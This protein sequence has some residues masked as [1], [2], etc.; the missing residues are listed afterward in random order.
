[1]KITL[2]PGSLAEQLKALFIK[3]TKKKDYVI[4]HSSLLESLLESPLPSSL[5]P[6]LEPVKL[7][8]EYM[9]LLSVFD[10]SLNGSPSMVPILLLE[11]FSLEKLSS[12]IVAVFPV[13]AAVRVL[14]Q[15]KASTGSIELK[16]SC[17]LRC[18]FGSEG[19][20]STMDP[21]K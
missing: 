4:H 2:N 11:A 8:Y 16:F 5:E 13:V 14:S 17:C 15:A 18:F 19:V 3:M 12:N 10:S 6:E 7:S 1:M 9:L 20:D 21:V